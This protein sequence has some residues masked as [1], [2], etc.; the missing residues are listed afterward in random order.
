MRGEGQ[1]TK[2]AHDDTDTVFRQTF[3]MVKG[4]GLALG[5]K[6]KGKG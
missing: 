5:L 2:I 1:T 6:G 4:K 3:L